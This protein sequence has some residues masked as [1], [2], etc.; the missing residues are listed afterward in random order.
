MSENKTGRYLKYALGEILLVMIGILLALQVNNWNEERKLES[1]EIQHLKGLV[2]DLANDT[3][4][5]N[6][7][8]EDS[9]AEIQSYRLYI[10]EAYREQKSVDDF[11]ELVGLGWFSSEHFV[12]NNSTYMELINAGQ[13]GIFKNQSIKSNI[14]ML[15]L[16]LYYNTN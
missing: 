12:F 5:F 7:R 13:L 15:V 11:K 9:E 6:R 3:T 14:V 10:R 4:Y 1:I 8:I 16:R 2:T